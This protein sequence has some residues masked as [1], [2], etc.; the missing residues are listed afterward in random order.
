MSNYFSLSRV[1]SPFQVQTN[2]EKNS[3]SANTPI[4]SAIPVD[5]GKMTRVEGVDFKTPFKKDN[6]QLKILNE[7]FRNDAYLE[8]VLGED[9]SPG[10]L[11]RTI[12][13]VGYIFPP[14]HIHIVIQPPPPATVGFSHQGVPQGTSLYSGLPLLIHISYLHCIYLL[15]HCA[16][17]LFTKYSDVDRRC[18]KKDFGGN[19]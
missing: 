6:E 3:L 16:F 5:I 13:P 1:L 7:N 18:H 14:N 17:L 10:E 2:F 11:I 4:N 9:L 15:I 19:S 8:Q 12:F